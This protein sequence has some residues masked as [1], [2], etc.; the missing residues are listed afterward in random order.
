MRRRIGKMK[1]PEAKRK[2]R[3]KILQRR[4]KKQRDSA[5]KIDRRIIRIEKELKE[6]E[7]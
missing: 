7:A 1:T 2:K 4:L 6:M 3:V 5:K